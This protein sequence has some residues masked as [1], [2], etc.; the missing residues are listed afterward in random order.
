MP[1]AFRQV[2]PYA[3][4]D[5]RLPTGSAG[6]VVPRKGSNLVLLED[7][8]ALKV[9]SNLSPTVQV[10]S[11]ATVSRSVAPASASFPAA[12]LRAI[13]RA[14]EAWKAIVVT[15]ATRTTVKSAA[16]SEYSAGSKMWASES[17]KTT[18]SAFAAATAATTTIPE[19]TSPRPRS[20]VN[21]MPR[22][23]SRLR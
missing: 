21:A 22:P 15:W 1:A 13:S 7:G 4:V 2:S 14:T 10:D 18:L 23:D 8:A 12:R 19:P 11:A 5:E 17:W 3:G 9:A 6:I 20:S 16:I